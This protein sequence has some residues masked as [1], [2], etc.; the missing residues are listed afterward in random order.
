MNERRL[1][2]VWT[3]GFANHII[4]KLQW[5]RFVKLTPTCRRRFGE[6][7]GLVP[8]I[9]EKRPFTFSPSIFWFAHT[10]FLTSLRQW[11]L[12]RLLWDTDLSK[13]VLKNPKR[14]L[15]AKCSVQEAG[16]FCKKIGAGVP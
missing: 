7:P 11:H 6:E 2:D 13:V 10:I 9:I 4:V 5:E 15:E 8:P 12:I 1:K 14:T 16:L 3:S